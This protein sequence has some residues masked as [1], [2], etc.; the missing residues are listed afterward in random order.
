MLS[1]TTDLVQKA[2]EA[3]E[4]KKREDFKMLKEQ[5]EDAL[6]VRFTNLSIIII[7]IRMIMIIKMIMVVINMMMMMMM[8]IVIVIILVYGPLYS[9]AFTFETVPFHKNLDC[10]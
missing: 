1:Y 9:V 7:I 5:M 6:K 8:I 10:F 3:V 2:K 4:L